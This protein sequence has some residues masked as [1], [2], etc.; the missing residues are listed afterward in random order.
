MGDEDDAGES[1][2]GYSEAEPDV[3]EAESTVGGPLFETL[4]FRSNRKSIRKVLGKLGFKKSD[5][6]QVNVVWN[7]L[8]AVS[9]VQLSNLNSWQRLG[10]IKGCNQFNNKL[11]LHHAVR[12]HELR[13]AAIGHHRPLMPRAFHATKDRKKL[14]KFASSKD[15]RGAMWICK[16]LEAAMGQGIF[17]CNNVHELEF[18]LKSRKKYINSLFV[19]E[20][21]ERPFLLRGLKF[22]LRVYVLVVCMTPLRVYIYDEGLVRYATTSYASRCRSSQLTNYSLNNQAKNF[23]N[24]TSMSDKTS[25]KQSF[26]ALKEQLGVL[27]VDCERAWRDMHQAVLEVVISMHCHCTGHPSTFQLLGFDVLFDELLQPQILE[28]QLA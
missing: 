11:C 1:S 7:V 24:A 25:H 16:P 12:D 5:S 20:Y 19:S 14:D 22:D 21:I 9:N 18:Q 17:V 10:T 28:V 6:S 2:D 4:S 8:R 27:G 23:K 13:A 3:E 15:K 26:A